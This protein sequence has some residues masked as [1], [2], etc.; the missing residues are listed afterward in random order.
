[1]KNWLIPLICC[2]VLL[3]VSCVRSQREIIVI[4]ATF[5][6]AEAVVP[7]VT[8]ILADVVESVPVE[9]LI[10][11]V[12]PIVLSLVPENRSNIP[13]PDPTRTTADVPSEHIVQSGDTLSGI[14]SRYNISLDAILEANEFLNPNVIEVGQVITL[15]QLILE[16]TGDFKIISDS[17][18]VRG[19]GS[20]Q[21]NV[22]N[23]VAQMPGYIRVATDEVTTR[24]ANG[25]QLDEILTGA[26]IVQRVAL[27][28]SVDPRILLALLEY[29]AGWLSQLNIS[30]NLQNY[31]LIRPDIAPDVDR[32]G[33]YLQLAWAANQLNQGYYGWRYRGLAT[34]TFSDSS[35]RLLNTS[36]NAGSV[37]LYHF[38]A[39]DNVPVSWQQDV[40]ES[41]LFNTYYQY[42]GDP[43]SN[44]TE[45]LI[46]TTI[47]QPELVLPFAPGEVWFYTGGYH[48]GW[49]S[50]SA[51]AAVDFAPPDERQGDDPLCYTSQSWATAVAPGIIAR[52]GDGV[53][54]LDLDGDGDEST[55]WSILYLHLASDGLV[56]SGQQ[57]VVGDNIGKPS[58]EGG[59]S[60]ATHMH[61]ARRYNGEWLPSDCQSCLPG[62]QI[63]PFTMS[64]WRV[65][66]IT[67]QQYQGYLEAIDGT[68]VIAEQGRNNPLNRISR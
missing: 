13:T 67:G 48:G 10:P 2:S 8:P 68:Q 56:A 18:L 12:P 16:V 35:Q 11:T 45:P 31:P 46:P 59:F 1:M 55:G 50:G 41:G 49:G 37:A 66:G 24:L 51:W 7:T 23:F 26:E 19:P 22:A 28:Y 30:E 33:L 54:I 44:P 17:R 15:P 58:C 34:I 36:L 32:S 25:S 27:E 43:F 60:T 21:F 40:S 52:S 9:T 38:L 65:I 4:T 5:Q 42:F 47:Q 57:V 63:P 62:L 3:L 6:P 61:I 20:S 29:R 39:I 53:A 64:S 14:A